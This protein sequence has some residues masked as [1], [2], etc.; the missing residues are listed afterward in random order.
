MNRKAEENSAGISLRAVEDASSQES[1]KLKRKAMNYK[2]KRTILP[3]IGSMFVFEMGHVNGSRRRT[4]RFTNL[5]ANTA[6]RLPRPA[7][8]SPLSGFPYRLLPETGLSAEPGHCFGSR[9]SRSWSRVLE[10]F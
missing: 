9:Q 3:A 1:T 4:E 10:G 2:D 7:P 5:D 6:T 8:R